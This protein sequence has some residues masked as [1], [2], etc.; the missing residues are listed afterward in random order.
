MR[1]YTEFLNK[2]I[3]AV[4]SSGFTPYL[5][6]DVLFPFQK[7]IVNRSLEKGR[8]GVFAD[9]GLGKTLIELE[10]AKQVSDYTQKPVLITCPLAVGGQTIK[11]ANKFGYGSDISKYGTDN[12]IQIINYEQLDN[13]D[14]SIFSGIA[15]D[16]SSILKNF[17]GAYRNLIIENFRSTPYKLACTATPAPNDPMELGNHSEFLNIMGRTEMLAMYYVHDGGETAK[18]RLKKHSIDP[19]Y[20]WVGQW[21]TMLTKPSDIG[22]DDQGYDLPSLNFIE[23]RII[24]PQREG[25]MFNDVAI[26]ATN[27]NQ[28]L[29]LTKDKRLARAAEI[30]N[31][32]DENFIVWIKQ[33]EEGEQLKKMIPGSIE[34]KGSDSPEYKEEML[35]GFADNK[36]RVLITKAKIAQFGLNYQN[37][38]NQVFASP[39]F[40]FESLYQA[41][42]RSYRF[43]QLHPVNI[44]ILVTDTMTN[45]INS[46]Q[47][48]QRQ[49]E[50][51]Q[52]IMSK[53]IAA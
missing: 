1:Q 9:C 28:E 37:C 29:R 40:S 4:Q 52:L 50:Q 18:W 25:K 14:A 44:Y 22:F 17:E 39:D 15:L 26:S 45:V 43:G 51:M 49:F 7:F 30:V 6:N 38:H 47:R 24:T 23:E 5:F 27:F 31:S 32:S 21:A 46:L 10:W 19:Y 11:E 35:L 2:K 8:T 34:V 13:V 20:K 36:F 41:V 16:E 53:S 42:R 3:S 48:K 33:N 12:A